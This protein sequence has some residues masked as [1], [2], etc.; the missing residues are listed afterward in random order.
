MLK[1]RNVGWQYAAAREYVM[2]CRERGECA[3]LLS[4]VGDE[5]DP[6]WVRWVAWWEAFLQDD[7]APDTPAS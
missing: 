1:D 2:A 3:R 5:P 7:D 4:R 6:E